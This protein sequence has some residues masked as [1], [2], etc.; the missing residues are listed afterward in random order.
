MELKDF[1]AETIRQ[2]I[3]GVREAQEHAS[4]VGASVNSAGLRVNQNHAG[5]RYVDGRTA[6]PV[7]DLEFD[8]A[9][10]AAEGTA[11]KGGIGVFVGPIALGSQ[12]RSDAAS[13][14]VSRIRFT[15]PVSLPQQKPPEE[16]DGR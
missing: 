3:D 9:V 10:T 4:T 13:S 14:S 6:Q 16:P 5:L 2:V 1:V 8:V 11:T 12:G 15:V 7:E